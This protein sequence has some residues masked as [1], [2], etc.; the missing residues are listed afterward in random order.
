[1]LHRH[2]IALLDHR[3]FIGNVGSWANVLVGTGLIDIT[4]LTLVLKA[5]LA[6]IEYDSVLEMLVSRLAEGSWSAH[7]VSSCNLQLIII[8][9]RSWHLKFEA[10]SVEDLIRVE[11]R[12]SAIEANLLAREGFIV[13]GSHLLCP[14]GSFV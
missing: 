7:A 12:G 6:S 5:T 11:T 8:L 3:V 14:L 9:S 10:L 2:V 13:S 1:M 4:I